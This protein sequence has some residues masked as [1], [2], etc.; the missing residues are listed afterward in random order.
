MLK[1]TE[2]P[3]GQHG[4]GGVRA[5]VRLEQEQSRQGWGREQTGTQ[6]LLGHGEDLTLTKKGPW[7]GFAEKSG[8]RR[9]RGS[10]LRGRR[11]GSRPCKLPAQ[12][13]FRLFP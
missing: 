7:E 5:E 8:S 3:G 9:D 10:R 2:Q 12:Y 11:Q 4:Q 6:G 1:F 13:P